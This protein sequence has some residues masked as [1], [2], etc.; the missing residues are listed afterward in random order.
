MWKNRYLNV[1]IINQA[2]TKQKKYEGGEGMDRQVRG[3]LR[4]AAGG[5]VGR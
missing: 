2:K 5:E 4:I 1:K 3:F